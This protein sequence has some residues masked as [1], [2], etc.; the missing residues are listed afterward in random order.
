M[1][2]SPKLLNELGAFI[3]GASNIS[4]VFS[5]NFSQQL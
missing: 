3:A 4:Y 2:H 5:N 1:K